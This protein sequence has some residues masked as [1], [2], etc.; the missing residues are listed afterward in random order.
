[1]PDNITTGDIAVTIN[2]KRYPR[3]QTVPTATYTITDTTDKINYRQSARFWQ[4]ELT[5]N[6]VGQEFV[7]G[8][9]FEE[10]TRGSRL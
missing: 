6:T 1:M 3:S 4:Y 5:G 8:Q 10:F 7:A 9:W 2:T